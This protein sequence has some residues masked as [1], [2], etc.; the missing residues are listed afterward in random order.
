MKKF[1]KIIATTILA[2]MLTLT[3][4]INSFATTWEYGTSGTGKNPFT[5][6]GYVIVTETGTYWLNSRFDNSSGTVF[7]SGVQNGISYIDA[8]KVDGSNYTLYAFTDRNPKLYQFLIAFKNGI[9]IPGFSSYAGAPG[10][11]TEENDLGSGAGWAIPIS[12]FEFEPGCYYEFA[13]QR[14]M[15]ANNGI[16]LVFSEDGKGYI[17]NP[18]TPEEKQKYEQ[19]KNQEYQFMSSYWVTQDPKTGDYAYD[20]HLVPMRFSVQ[21]YADLTTWV[22]GKR[23]A[24]EFLNSVTTEQISSGKYNLENI[25][26]LKLTM[27]SLEKEAETSIKKQLQT[28]AEENMQL[29]LL[30]L[31]TALKKAQ[32]PESPAADLETLRTL[33]QEANE[34]YQTASANTGTETGQYGEAATLAL[35]E[36]IDSASALTEKD[37]Q[38]AINEAISKLEEAMTRVYASIVREDSLILFDRA[39]GIKALIPRGIVPDDVV[40]YVQTLSNS[41]EVYETLQN[42]FGQDTRI[43]AY[44]IELYSHDLKVQPAGEFELQIPALSGTN[45]GASIV[46]TVGDDMTTAQTISAEANGYKLLSVNRTG[47]FAVAAAASQ[48]PSPENAAGNESG[49][50]NDTPAGPDQTETKA[51][52]EE[53]DVDVSEEPDANREELDETEGA[54]ATVEDPEVTSP[55]PEQEPLAPVSIPIDTIKKN[56]GSPVYILL[57]AALLAAAAAVVAGHGFLQRRKKRDN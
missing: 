9:E 43:A 55:R 22:E 35:K 32:S 38:I 54:K 13:F 50:A 33:L 12:G 39:S 40:L 4:S 52:V 42:A 8:K 30:E 37:S 51:I 2:V 45:P 14:G 20:F 18:E 57:V 1:N 48:L 28:T 34:L 56:A 53:T 3:L 19:D 5:P 41:D 31:K 26:E 6:R 10:R 11:L 17:Q 49:D 7:Y 29:M 24:A 23:E 46:Y 16:T 47:M 36:A 27:E 21:T 44:N 15:Q 25:T